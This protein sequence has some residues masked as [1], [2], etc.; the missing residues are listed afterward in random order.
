[1]S[2]PPFSITLAPE[3]T[4]SLSD[5]FVLAGDRNSENLFLERWYQLLK[6]GGRLAVVLP[7]STFATKENFKARQFLLDHFSI[8]AIVSLPRHAFEPWTPT[9]TCLLF[10]IKKT[11]SQEAAWKVRRETVAA[12]VKT[13][14]SKTQRLARRLLKAIDSKHADSNSLASNLEAL[15][16]LLADLDQPPLDNAGNEFGESL[17]TSLDELKQVDPSLEGLRAAAGEFAEE[18]TAITVSSIGYKR[19]KRTEY[20]R[21]NELFSAF[22]E[23]EDSEG[24]LITERVL[25]LNLG[26]RSWYVEIDDTDGVDVLSTLVARKIWES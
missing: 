23:R 7:E 17:K 24:N 26:P 18:Y 12:A 11:R 16:D 25:N 8:R 1:V 21:P 13:K 5:S 22:S 20:N 3:T 19:T 10:A 14:K 6:P 4:Q 9:R 15:N 2:N